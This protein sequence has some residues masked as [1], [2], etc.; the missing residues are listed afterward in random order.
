[1]LHYNIGNG[2][3]RAGRFSA[4]IKAYESALPLADVALQE[5]IFFNLGNAQYQLGMEQLESD[6]AAT[7]G[8]WEE[9]LKNYGNSLAINPDAGDA[10]RN[11]QW[12]R[13]QC[14]ARGARIAVAPNPST[15]GSTSEGGIFLPGA[16]L[17][18][19]AE[20]ADGWRFVRWEGAEV[21]GPDGAN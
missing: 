17:P 20:P 12:V 9:A 16:I 2:E 5:R 8:L 11:Q 7:T 15:G 4:A 13:G 19:R 14:S 18:V 6:P 10:V 1:R 21:A 3:Y